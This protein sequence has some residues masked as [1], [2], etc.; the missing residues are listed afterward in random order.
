MSELIK[1]T[2]VDRGSGFA[3]AID[4][5]NDA[6]WKLANQ[7]AYSIGIGHGLER[8]IYRLIVAEKKLAA[9]EQEVNS[10]HGRIFERFYQLEARLTQLEPQTKKE[11]KENESQSQSEH[12][13]TN[14]QR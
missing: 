5:I 3:D 1:Q 13:G 6:D 7:M 4:R 2:I 10:M 11:V 8:V 9:L 12:N 14:R